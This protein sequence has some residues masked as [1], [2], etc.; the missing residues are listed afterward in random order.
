[1]NFN[2]NDLEEYSFI[3]ELPQTIH[4]FRYLLEYL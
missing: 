2:Q 1:M 4:R 3:K